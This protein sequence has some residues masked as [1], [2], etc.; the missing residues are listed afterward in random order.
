MATYEQ[1]LSTGSTPT[2][3][4]SDLT[5]NH[6]LAQVHVQR[7]SGSGTFE[8]ALERGRVGGPSK[9]LS[10]R[11][12]LGTR[13]GAVVRHHAG[14][15]PAAASMVSVVL[16]PAAVN[17]LASP[18]RPEWAVTPSTPADLAAAA[19]RR[20]IDWPFNPRKT[21]ASGAALAGRNAVSAAAAP[22]LASVHPRTPMFGGSF[23]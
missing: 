11:P 2:F 22:F 19:K 6:R 12:A 14:S 15:L 23:G 4:H 20:P 16:A 17:S 7:A 13:P 18:T 1:A 21:S 3:T 9:V 10:N 5:T 8:V